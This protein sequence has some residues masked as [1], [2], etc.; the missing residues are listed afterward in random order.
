MS[1]VHPVPGG[2]TGAPI[3]LRCAGARSPGPR[4]GRCRG[5]WGGRSRSGASGR[6]RCRWLCR[7]SSRAAPVPLVDSGWGGRPCRRVADCHGGHSPS[8]LPALSCRAAVRRN[9]VHSPAGALRTDGSRP[10]GCAA[11]CADRGRFRSA[12]RGRGRDSQS[13]RALRAGWPRPC[14][15][16]GFPFHIQFKQESNPM[17]KQLLISMAAALPLLAQVPP[18]GNSFQQTGWVRFP[19]AGITTVYPSALE[20]QSGPVLGKPLSATEVRRTEQIL[21]DGSRINN[22]ET[23]FFYRDSQGRMLTKTSTGAVMFDPV[24][25]FSYDL[26]MRNKTYTKSP[27][28]SNTAVTIAA[29]AHYSS[30]N[31]GGAPSKPSGAQ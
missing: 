23:E 2:P 15:P 28:S 5:R 20:G 13:R 24:A 9:P 6:I 1:A 8:G 14:H 7:G 26:T 16:P 12:H 27:I 22:S 18:A 4:N 21:S 11:G 31:S 29:A 10:H 30:V 17:T 3:R 25:G 19:G